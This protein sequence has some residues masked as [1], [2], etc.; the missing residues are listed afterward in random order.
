MA[1]RIANYNKRLFR[2]LKERLF[3]LIKAGV[4][5][6]A[7]MLIKK[8]KE[9]L[10][11]WT[12]NQMA[13]ITLRADLISKENLEKESLDFLR[14]FVKAI[15]GGNLENIEAPE[16]KPIIEILGNV[17]RSRATQGFTPSETATYIFSLK[18]AIL[19]Y[20]QTE[21]ADQPDILNRE[22]VSVSKLLDKLGL[23]TFETF[24]K[25]RKEMIAQQARSILELSTPVITVWEKVLSVPLIG[26][27]DS[28]RTQLVMETLLQKIVDTQSRVVILDISGI[29]TVDTLVAN[30]LIR[31]VTATGVSAK[32]AQTLVH[33][34]V[35]L[36]GITTRPSMADG[37]AMA[38]DIL[39]LR[40]GPKTTLGSLGGQWQAL[41]DEIDLKSIRQ[42]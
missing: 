10:G 15:S 11:T 12:E 3:W 29:P 27:L 26:V 35:D 34:G 32:I 14:A 39:N 21:L 18:D 38:F 30:H 25:S 31:T 4:L 9:I 16:Y 33:L 13:N 40:V 37:I 28:A 41:K 17:S 19:Q 7:E 2:K 36:S 20:L 8:E 22:V 24:T 6:T 23:M 5:S 42:P 1:D